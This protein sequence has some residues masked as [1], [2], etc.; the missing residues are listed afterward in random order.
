M[1]KRISVLEDTEEILEIIKIVLEEE[2]YDVFGF[3][4]VSEFIGNLTR[5]S[6]DLCLLDVM[7]PDGNGLDVC[8]D[9]K[10]AENTKHIPIIIM[11]ANAQIEKMKDECAADDF[12]AKPFDID[13]LTDKISGLLND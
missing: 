8:H 7:L 13:N 5:I 1:N 9:L 2:Q 6:P 12:I 4:T 10:A 11:T 3:A